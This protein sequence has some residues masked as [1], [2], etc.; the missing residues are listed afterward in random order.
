MRRG[1]NLI[2]RQAA[3]LQPHAKIYILT[4]T[5]CRIAHSAAT[6]S[7]SMVAFYM[8]TKHRI[9]DQCHNNVTLHRTDPQL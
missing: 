9:L 7:L 2:V 1:E 6:T 4:N 5:W 3:L 8:A